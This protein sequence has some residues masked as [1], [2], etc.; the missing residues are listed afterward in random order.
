M[1]K[2]PFSIFKTFRLL[3]F[4]F[5]SLV[6]GGWRKIDPQTADFRLLTSDLQTTRPQDPQTY[7]HWL[8]V[9]S[10]WKLARADPPT[11]DF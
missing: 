11:S 10:L 8:L 6:F 4:S 7:S 3:V 1:S 2:D 5:W 9:F